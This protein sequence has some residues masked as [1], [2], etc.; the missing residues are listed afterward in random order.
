MRFNMTI[1][2]DT[3]MGQQ[4]QSDTRKDKSHVIFERHCLP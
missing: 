1:T 2:K 3:P 4:G